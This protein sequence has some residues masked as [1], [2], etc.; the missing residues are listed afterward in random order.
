M[1]EYRAAVGGA[2]GAA[3]LVI[4]GKSMGGRVASMVADEL[5]G[6]PIAGLAVPRLSVPSARAAGAAADDASRGAADAGADRAGDA[7]S[8][9][10]AG[11]GR[12]LPPVA[13]DPRSLWLEDGDH[14]LKPR[15]AVSGLT[16]GG[17]PCDDGAGGGRP[18]CRD[19]GRDVQRQQRGEAAGEPAGVAGGGGAR[20]GL[21][22]GAE[23]GGTGF[24]AAAL[25][26]AGYAAVWRGQRAW[27]GVA[28]LAR[29]GEPVVTRLALPGD[30]RTRRRAISRR[31]SGAC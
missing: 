24:P 16:G 30:G 19:E 23:G 27:N 12:G 18:G 1:G 5:L 15:K 20:R 2:A 21:P 25:A 28:I 26:A 22:A 4:G 14:D 31:R 8:V 13:G 17:A 6:G 10:D 9:R 7:G 11:G 29:G 3:P